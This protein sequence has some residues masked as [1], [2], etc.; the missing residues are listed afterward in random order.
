MAQDTHP[1]KP[2]SAQLRDELQPPGTARTATSKAIGIVGAIAS[3]GAVGMGVAQMG[4]PLKGLT[5]IAAGGLGLVLSVNELKVAHA[6][7]RSRNFVELRE[8]IDAQQL[9]QQQRSR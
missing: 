2:V 7:A 9:A 4:S 8:K 6:A 3:V 1:I 5:K